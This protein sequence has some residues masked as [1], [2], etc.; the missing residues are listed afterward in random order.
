[1]GCCAT[2]N[3]KLGF[4]V[5]YIYFVEKGKEWEAGLISSADSV[6]LKRNRNAFPG[7]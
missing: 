5:A 1:M 7:L 2:R 6:I 3:Y 4:F